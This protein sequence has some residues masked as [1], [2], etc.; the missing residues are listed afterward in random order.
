MGCSDNWNGGII[1][2]TETTLERDIRLSKSKNKDIRMK[3]TLLD[4]NYMPVDSIV[5]KI[6]SIT[7]NRTNDSLIRSTCSLTMS[8]AQ[9]DQI[10]LDIER[11]WNKRMIKLE[12]GIYDK[13]N[14][15][16]V[17]Y[18][19]GY[20]LMISGK[21]KFDGTTQEVTLSLSDLMS[22]LAQERGNQIGIRTVIEA[23]SNVKQAITDIVAEFSEFDKTHVCE[24][25]D[26]IPYDIEVDTGSYPIEMLEQILEIFPTHEMF[27]DS[28]GYFTVQ[29]I[30][31]KI[32]DPIDFDYTVL[33]DLIISESKDADY[34][35]V[36]NTTELWGRELNADYASLSCA[37]IGDTYAVNL[38]DTF[39]GLISGELYAV[40]P[41]T[42]SVSG[43]K[44]KIQ[45]G[46]PAEG[47][48]QQ[49]T[50]T[51]GIYTEHMEAVDDEIVVV[52]DPIPAGTMI[53]DMP[54]V[55]KYN[56][57]RFIF[58]GEFQVRVIVQEITEE[59]SV[60]A[61]N[62]YKDQNGT[63]NVKWIINPDNPYACTLSP[64]TGR[65]QGEI[66]QV[67]SDGEFS[68]IY[69]T[70]LAYERAEYENWK[71]CRMQDTI[72]IETIL[73]PWMEIND[74]I[75]YT[76]PVSG[77]KDTWLVQDIDYDF[78]N[79]TMEIKASRFYPYYPWD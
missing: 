6:Q 50:E 75:R 21:S 41:D 27:Y 43:Q 48:G 47:E 9:K 56:D 44:M 58:Q 42:D 57:G 74:K 55:I 30:P 33:D 17:W 69:T 67:L 38:G 22:R 32:L 79:W 63:H 12:C 16:Y 24:F 73:I 66:K 76:S 8:I 13:E 78:S 64:S 29:P 68:N 28:D 15:E 1:M 49:Y 65:I 45:I 39:I 61:E 51:Y 59:P 62:Y 35:Q 5:G 20:M 53:A 46:T 37:T 10:N 25:D 4:S 19:L 23:G 18:R 77:D 14:S 54:Y 70:Q 60:F 36:K 26:T 52:Y 11:T 3:A 72:S 7:Y 71:K 2:S 40:V 31:T 34:S